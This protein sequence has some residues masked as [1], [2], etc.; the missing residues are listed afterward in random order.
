MYG[1]DSSEWEVSVWSGRHMA[2]QIDKNKYAVYEILLCGSDW[3]VVKTAD[4]QVPAEHEAQIDKTDF[5]FT[6]KGDRA[7]FEVALLMIHGKPGED[8]AL[9]AYFEGLQ[10]PHTAS[11]STVSALAFDKYACK[12]QLRNAGIAMAKDMLL[13]EDED[14]DEQAVVDTLGLPLFVK[15][16]GGGSSFGAT[17][18]RRIEEL[19]PALELA[20]QECPQALVEEFMA[21]R[22]LTNGVLKT[23]DQQLVLP[24]TEIVSKND[25]FDYQAKYQGASDEITPAPIPDA[26]RD[27]VQRLTSQIYDYLGCSGFIRID[28]IARDEE[29]MF[30]EVNTIPGMTPMSLVP[31]QVSVAGMS[32]GTFLEWVIEDAIYRFGRA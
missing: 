25:F 1:G 24:V 14:V 22:E 6:W 27:K 31:Q 11:S 7:L 4:G 9:P 16:N 32:M 17:K 28:Y 2:S 23:H 29:V 10:I 21:G 30:L 18:V 19:K 8:G 3:R 15:P 20:F 13:Q 12:S 5:S 26:L